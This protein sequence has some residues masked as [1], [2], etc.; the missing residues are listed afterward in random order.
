MKFLI[1]AAYTYNLFVIKQNK[2][3][4]IAYSA[5]DPHP[6]PT[7]FFVPKRNTQMLEVWRR[8]RIKSQSE[9]PRYRKGRG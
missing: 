5:K 7:A 2:T 6:L 9:D 1:H 4:K 8:R 3:N